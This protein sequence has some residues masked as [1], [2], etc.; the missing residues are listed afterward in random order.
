[1]AD[2]H[3]KSLTRREFDEVIRRA[4]ELAARESD[5]G[6]GA[7]E[8]T[9]LMR[10]ARE[11]GLP[12]RHVRAALAELRTGSVMTE[13]GGAFARLFGP[14]TIRATRV[15]S[16]T[17]RQIADK[18]DAF[19]VGGQLLQSVRRTER[20]LQYRPAVDWASQVARVASATTRSYYVAAA[21]SVE[22]R[23]EEMEPGRTLV[24]F[25]VDPGTRGDAVGGAIAGTFAGAAA[26]VGSAILLLA[27]AP[28]G[29]AVAGGTVVAA[30][31]SGGSISWAGSIQRRKLRDVLS[32]VEGILDK[33]E[34]GESLEPPPP[35]WRQWVKRHFHGVARDLFRDQ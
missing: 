31:I 14:E 21:R 29:L 35:A 19:L 9:E 26:G 23:L 32:E 7:L 30:A 6:E 25:V 16:G 28:L 20:L 4:S 34:T 8:E 10:I 24:D 12:E 17:P 22:V 15:V 2:S 27:T 13:R 1:V 3:E 11:V 5:A 18:L 33:L